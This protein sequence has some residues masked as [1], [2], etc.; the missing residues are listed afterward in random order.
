MKNKP[1][2]TNKQKTAMGIKMND[3]GEIAHYNDKV[4]ISRKNDNVK[5]NEF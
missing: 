5:P 4:E 2:F 1:K 3:N